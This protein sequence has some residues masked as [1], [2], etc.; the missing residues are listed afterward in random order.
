MHEGRSRISLQ[1]SL[2]WAQD[3]LMF[4]YF[5]CLIFYSFLFR[6]SP[7]C[8]CLTVCAVDFRVTCVHPSQ[9][10]KLGP[11]THPA[12]AQVSLLGSLVAQDLPGRQHNKNWGPCGGVASLFDASHPHLLVHG[13]AASSDRIPGFPLGRTTSTTSENG[14][15]E[16]S[17]A[18]VRRNTTSPILPP[19]ITNFTKSPVIYLSPSHRLLLRAPALEVCGGASSLSGRVAQGLAAAGHSRAG[20]YIVSCVS[21]GSMVVPTL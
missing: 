9:T 1:V 2:K 5:P 13:I 14:E 19:S 18:V 16:A 4:L 12:N 20:D 7:F 8:C 15:A 21:L 3:F 11:R 17:C 6:F 10:E